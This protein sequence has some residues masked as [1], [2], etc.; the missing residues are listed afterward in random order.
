M[1]YILGQTQLEPMLV[2]GTLL[3]TRLPLNFSEH[4]MCVCDCENLAD[5]KE[6][7]QEISDM[8]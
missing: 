5:I 2:H 7:V 8:V 6:N 1:S 4:C 3:T